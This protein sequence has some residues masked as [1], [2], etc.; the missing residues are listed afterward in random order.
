MRTPNHSSRPLRPIPRLPRT[1]EGPGVRAPQGPHRLNI[2]CYAL[3]AD[4]IIKNTEIDEE[5]TLFTPDTINPHVQ[6][7]LV[8]QKLDSLSTLN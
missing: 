2:E 1:G 8:N 5:K 7:G 3:D 4:S 6:P